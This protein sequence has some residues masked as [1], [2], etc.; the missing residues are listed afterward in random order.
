MATLLELTS[1]GDVG[2]ISD[3]SQLSKIRLMSPQQL[4]ELWERQPW[5]AHAID[6]TRD[7]ADWRGLDGETRDDVIWGLSSFFVGEERVTTQFSG[8][9]M[10]Y[11]DQ[12]EEAYLATQQVDEARH[13]Q[14]FA[15]FYDQVVAI[16][17]GIDEQLA[18]VRDELNDAFV[19]LFDEHLVRA[20]E[21]LV[22][23]PSDLEA[24][25]DFV[26]TYHMVIE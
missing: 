20:G 18:R 17:G 12:A 1:Q 10:A 19:T 25:V 16:G 4:Y 5:S 22:A 11:A 8:L 9:V 13:V 23:D 24:K 21:R 7:V 3:E 14:H 2:T 26:T 15:R 6:L